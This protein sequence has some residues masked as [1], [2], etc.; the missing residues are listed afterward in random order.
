MLKSAKQ[1]L[2]L[3]GGGV[4]IARANKEL[5]EFVEK[6][7]VPLLTTIMGK[8]A[9]PTEHPLYLGNAGMHGKYA[10]NTAVSECDVLFSIGTRFNDRIT[11]DLN[12]FAPNAKIIHIDVD[13]ASISRNVVVDVP[14][15]ADAK[16]ALRKL[17]EWAAPVDTDEW[18]AKIKEWDDEYPMSMP[19][20]E[21]MT[22]Q[23]VMEGINEVFEEAIYVTDVGQNQMWATQFLEL[24]EKKMMITSGG[25]GTMGFGF[26]AALGAK[27]ARP[28][29]P[30]VCVTGDGGFQMNMQEM[31]TAMCEQAP[32]VICLLNNTYLGMVR[33]MQQLFYGKRYAATCL[34]R[35]ITCPADCKGPGP[36]CPEYT[37][38]FVKVAESYGAHGIRVTEADQ[39]IPALKQAASYTDGPTIIEFM[40]NYED[41][42]LPMVRSGNPTYDMIL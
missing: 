15:V 30:V 20:S 32:V 8:G 10:C 39:I 16:K 18:R 29:K 7:N 27:I 25:L 23:K 26:P 38:D 9:I 22:P 35:R 17:N 12:E 28:Q 24:N 40:I 3:A 42:V 36:Q 1:P 6:S 21:G 14:V 11:G 33:Q 34:N 13:T 19:D 2:I 37:P 31:A 41:I 5:L 4:K